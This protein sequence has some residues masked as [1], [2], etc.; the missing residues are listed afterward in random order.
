MSGMP[1]GRAASV[2]S[3]TVQSQK[4]RT[5]GFPRGLTEFDRIAAGVVVTARRRRLVLA[6]M[7]V[8]AAIVIIVCT[9]FGAAHL[10]GGEVL[11]A[12]WRLV[13]GGDVDES[14]G[15][16]GVILF[17][18]RL[19]RVLMGFLVGC[20]LAAVGATLQALLRNPLADPYVLGISSGAALGITLATLLAGSSLLVQ[21]PVAPVWGFAGGLIALVVI[22]RMAQS[23]GRLPVHGL[24][25]A[26]VVL[27]AVLTAFMMFITSIMDPVRSAGL[28]AWLMGSVT[29]REW[30][31]LLGIAAY[32][33]IGTAWLWS[34]A[35]VLNLLTQ[36]EETARSLGIDVEQAKK[37]LYVVTALLVGAVVSVSGM[38]GFV[39]MVVPHI[40][41]MAFGADH[42]LL[43][44]AAALVGGIFLVISDTV[45]RTILAPSEIPVGV[46]TALAGGPVFLYFLL[47]QKSRMV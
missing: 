39:G 20:T 47:A 29:V 17:Q 16:V 42:R 35:P 1:E 43:L 23:H 19:P 15:P 32:V 36:G 45:A 4:A 24:L 28:I 38:I 9:A 21:T 10:G 31:G 3:V 44:P 14:L 12:W 30:V 34:H 2:S 26:G 6:G 41:R 8:A 18:V 7:V 25:L 22:Y 46:V 37:R 33:A 27:N 40:V 13:V 11:R 5:S